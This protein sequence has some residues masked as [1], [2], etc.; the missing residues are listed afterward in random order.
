M[1]QEI[2]KKIKEAK[3]LL[4]ECLISLGAETHGPKKAKSR[5]SSNDTE[6]SK[7]NNYS[8]PKGGVLLLIDRDFFASK[9]TLEDVCSA[10]EKEG[11]IYEKD[12]IRVALFRLSKP[13]GPLKRI[14]EGSKKVYVK[15]K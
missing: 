12:V 15:R 8:G 10:M 7:S 9:K 6:I 14:E 4:E 2:I 3:M 11:Y 5:I 1:S 13:N